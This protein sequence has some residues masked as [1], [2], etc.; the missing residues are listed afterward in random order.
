M[1]K[2]YVYSKQTMPRQL[3]AIALLAIL[4]QSA[5]A[6]QTHLDI[7]VPDRI[8][9][10]FLGSVKRVLTDDCI[11][12]ADNHKKEE[13]IYDRAGNELSLTRW[14]TDGEISYAMTNAYDESGCH[15]SWHS[16]D[17]AK[18]ETNDWEV[19]LNLPTHQ[20]A[21]RN[22]GNGDTSVYTYSPEKR[23]MHY[24][25]VDKDK[26]TIRSSKYRRRPEDNK[27]TEYARF[28]ERNRPTYTYNYRWNDSLFVDRE[29]ILYHEDGT[30]RLIVNEF[31]K[32]DE[33]GNWTQRISIRYK[34]AGSEQ[35]K[36]YET[37]TLRTIEY[38]ED[39]PS[40]DAP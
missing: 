19:V 5:T 3:P 2:D 40:E 24:R 36:L 31:L 30:K 14:G 33:H 7:R 35:T 8:S 9:S 34:I 6:Q 37:T 15:V 25:K 23:L 22:L 13:R 39:N 11:N 4:C 27:E 1:Y 38:F 16:E 17:F 21:M 10:D 32:T 29:S 18:K 20:I 26:K 28:D 12:L